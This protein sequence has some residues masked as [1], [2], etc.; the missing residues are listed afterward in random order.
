M[1]LH[2]NNSA[3]DISLAT[4][5]IERLNIDAAT[6]TTKITG[7]ATTI[8]AI[9][10][11]LSGTFTAT[12]GSDEITAG[13]STAFTTELHVGAAV[14]LVSSVSGSF[15]TFTVSAIGSATAFTL[16]SNY[17]GTTR[18]VGSG[19]PGSGFRDSGEL[20][21]VK[22]GDSQTILAVNGS[23]AMTFGTKPGT[24]DSNIAIGDGDALDTLT[25]GKSNIILG[26]ASDN[27]KLT[28]GKR[29]I[30]MGYRAGEDVVSNDNNVMIGFECAQAATGADNVFIG[31]EVAKNASGDDNVSI[32][33]GSMLNCTGDKNVAIGVQA[34]DASGDADNSVAVGYQALSAATN[35]NNVAIGFYAMSGFNGADSVAIGNEAL[36][37]SSS[38]KSTAVG[39]QCLTGLQS[40]SMEAN[41]GFGYRAGDGLDTGQQCTFLGAEADTTLVDG[42]NQTAIGYG[43]VTDAANQVRVG[44]TSVADIDGQVALTATSDARVKTNVQD[45]SLGLDFINALRPV[46]FSR[47]HPADWPEEIRDRRYKVG[48]TKKRD[49]LDEDGN[50]TGTEEITVSTSTFDVETGQPIKDEFD[51][52]TRSDGLIAQ[53]VKAACETLGVEF[54]GIKENSSGKMGIQYSLLV[55]PLIA[56]VQELTSQNES[57]AAR[58]ATLEAGD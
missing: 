50:V 13:D 8:G 37:S 55:A 53:E 26:H 11:A 2:T 28:T 57:L 6:G 9:A 15:E 17:L 22:T 27:Y 12:Q 4:N 25:T 42:N 23:G 30:F 3:T 14:K 1:L 41:S 47:V 52:T 49:I 48:Q 16:D 18:T 19:T 39:Y 20:F 5:Y 7:P 21:A 31:A 38:V 56:A 35:D 36:D 45:L 46:S 10:T 34:L 58:I 32:G 29:N 44:N 24:E 51:S 43:A 33:K 40:G 54:N